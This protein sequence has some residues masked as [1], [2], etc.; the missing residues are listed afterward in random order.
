[1]CQ[2]SFPHLRAVFEEYS[3]VANH[4][5]EKA[6]EKEFS[7]NAKKSLLTI[8]VYQVFYHLLLSSLSFDAA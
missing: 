8:G 1:M 3:K 4:D 5:I 7:Y 2:R 6:I